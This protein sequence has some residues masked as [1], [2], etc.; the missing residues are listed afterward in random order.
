MELVKKE[1]PK[2]AEPKVKHYYD[3]TSDAFF[4]SSATPDSQWI[5]ISDMESRR[6]VAE[7]KRGAL[8][9][10][11]SNGRPAAFRSPPKPEAK[12]NEIITLLPMT[13]VAGKPSQEYH[14]EKMTLEQ[15]IAKL[16]EIRWNKVQSDAFVFVDNVSFPTTTRVHDEIMGLTKLASTNMDGKLLWKVTATDWRSYNGYELNDIYIGI[17]K[18]IQRHFDIEFNYITALLA[19]KEVNANEWKLPTEEV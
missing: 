15:S 12:W 6:L 9:Y 8:V 18:T 5:E 7:Q 14:I 11:A 17:R 1:T 10:I 16:A 2:K 4:E 19:G 13:V 3:P